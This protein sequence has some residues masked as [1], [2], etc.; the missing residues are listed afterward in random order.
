LQIDPDGGRAR[1][2][3]RRMPALGD[4]DAEFGGGGCGEILGLDAFGSRGLG[5]AVVIPSGTLGGDSCMGRLSAEVA[6]VVKL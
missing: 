1:V 6:F 2:A 5:F 3:R 4:G